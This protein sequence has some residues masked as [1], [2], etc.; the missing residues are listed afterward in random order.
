MDLSLGWANLFR[1]DSFGLM[2]TSWNMRDSF[3]IRGLYAITPDSADLK[4]LIH[5]TQL[6]IQGGVFMVQYRSKFKI[7]TLKCSNV[8]LF[9]VFVVIIM[10]PAL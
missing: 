2:M 4:T 10:S 8:M 9:Y 5:K 7:M 1:T 6:A 3:T